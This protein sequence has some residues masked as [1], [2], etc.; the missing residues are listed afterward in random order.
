MSEPSPV[1][2][3][4]G[5]TRT[6]VA[7]GAASPACEQM[8]QEAK[9]NVLS[10]CSYLQEKGLTGVQ[11]SAF[12]GNFIWESG[13]SMDPAKQQVHGTARGIAQWDGGRL[14]GLEDYAAGRSQSPWT[15]SVQQDFVWHEI[16]SGGSESRVMRSLTGVT[17]IDRATEIVMQQYERP[18]APT[19]NLGAR[20][21]AARWV[22]DKFAPA[23]PGTEA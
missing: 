18:Y 19:A 5:T 23:G 3:A 14:K 6:E 11:S 9:M 21:E 20:Q 10:V 17:D 15:L 22:L 2:P 4:P 16:G 1:E 7:A 8:S 12:V 13:Y